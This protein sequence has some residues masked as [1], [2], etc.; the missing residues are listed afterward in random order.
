MT[1]NHEIGKIELGQSYD[2]TRIDFLEKLIISLTERVCA[3][4]EF[5]KPPKWR[6]GK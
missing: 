2:K 1:Q 6:E 5:V 3:L 4:E